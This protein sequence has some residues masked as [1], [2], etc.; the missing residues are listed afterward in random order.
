MSVLDAIAQRGS[1]NA[2]KKL[3]L[4]DRIDCT[5]SDSTYARDD[6]SEAGVACMRNICMSRPRKLVETYDSCGG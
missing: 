2:W 1:E 4:I 3:K 6:G 5:L